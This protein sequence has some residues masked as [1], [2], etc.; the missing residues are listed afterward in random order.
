MS[1]IIFHHKDCLDGTL[2]AGLMYE[3]LFAH[4][5]EADVKGL[6]YPDTINASLYRDKDIIILDYVIPTQVQLDL[7][8]NNNHVYYIDHHVRSMD[9]INEVRNL[10]QPTK[11]SLYSVI[12]TPRI[13]AAGLASIFAE[14]VA[15]YISLK[16]KA[17]SSVHITNE[18]ALL[19]FDSTVSLAA[20]VAFNDKLD[21]NEPGLIHVLS[22][23]DAYTNYHRITE[24]RQTRRGME[25]YE[26]IEP[27]RSFMTYS[28][29]LRRYRNDWEPLRAKGEEL[30]ALDLPILEEAYTNATIIEGEIDGIRGPQDIRFAVLYCPHDK[31]NL[32]SA[33]CF[34]QDPKI[35]FVSC[36][37]PS[38]DSGTLLISLR[39]NNL[40]NQS[41]NLSVLAQGIYSGSGGH[42][43]SAGSR[44]ENYFDDSY[45]NPEEWEN[46][47]S[48]ANY[49]L[50]NAQVIASP[51]PINPL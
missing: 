20:M 45:R 43:N 28:Y 35:S 38:D 31:V 5:V 11:T 26:S 27:E 2:A 14:T 6:Q 22:N 49:R 33:Y 32:V 7:I 25:Y 36:G 34:A 40:I 3:Q 18:H 51:E 21:Y 1:T 29:L 13:S 44:L 41:I 47:F 23:S 9:F 4:G 50:S 12:Y 30:E 24:D 15:K 10:N 42:F 8:N 39:G 37:R 46:H 17:P 19:N 16:V 48:A